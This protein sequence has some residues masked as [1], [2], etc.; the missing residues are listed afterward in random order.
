MINV[1][2]IDDDQEMTEAISLMLHLLDCEATSFYDARSAVDR[3]VAGIRPDLVLLDINFPEVSGLDMLEY[4]RRNKEWKDLP[5]IMLSSET[6]DTVVDQAIAMGA[7]GYIMKPVTLD[8]L[9]NAITEVN[10]KTR[11]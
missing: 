2:I 10:N 9:Q 11:L 7:D 8:E 5:V 4:L 6:A 1:W 3:L